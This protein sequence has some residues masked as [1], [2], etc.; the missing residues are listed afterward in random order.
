VVETA[1]EDP[2]GRPEEKARRKI[3][4]LLEDA[5]WAVQDRDNFDPRASKS[6]VVGKVSRGNCSMIGFD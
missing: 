6:I 3:D 2:G 1:L 5:G 4:R